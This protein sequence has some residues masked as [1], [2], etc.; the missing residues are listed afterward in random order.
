MG[1]RCPL[2]KPNERDTGIVKFAPD[3]EY[4]WQ[5]EHTIG[6]DWNTTVYKDDKVVEQ[7][8]CKSCDAWWGYY[9]K[10]A[11]DPKR[12]HCVDCGHFMRRVTD[13]LRF[14]KW[15]DSGWWP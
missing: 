11:K 15:M 14:K 9:A 13:A 1:L 8:Y 7:W 10:A 3:A 12:N 2:C 5:N 6:I 4:R